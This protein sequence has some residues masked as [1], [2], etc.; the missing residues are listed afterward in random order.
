MCSR[1][2]KDRVIFSLR[3]RLLPKARQSADALTDRLERYWDIIRLEIFYTRELGLS[4]VRE[5]EESNSNVFVSIKDALGSYLH[6]KNAGRSKTFFQG[7]ELAVGYLTK[8]TG[9]EEL[10]SLSASDA[11]RFCDHLIG[12]GMT[13]AS[14]RRVFGT[15]KAITN[16]AIREYGLSFP[17]V[18]A[19][20]FI[21]DEEKASTRLPI[22][23]ETLGAIQKVSLM[24][25]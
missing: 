25:D 20:I 10:A 23:D 22:P 18:F 5:V 1:F 16:L 14:V 12:K 3:T 24:Y 7:A 11:A 8:V 21:P 4:V 6:L 17:K 9:A 13:A 15:V 2:N 19:N